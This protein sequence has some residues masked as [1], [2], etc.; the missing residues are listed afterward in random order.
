[1][2]KENP[3]QPLFS[4]ARAVFDE[5]DKQADRWMEY[6]IAQTNEAAKIARGF[7]AQALGAGR[8]LLDTVENLTRSASS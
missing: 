2:A 7:R 5:C 6:G 1:M 8:A 3:A 4:L